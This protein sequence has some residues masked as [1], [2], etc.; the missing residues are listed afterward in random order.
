[1]RIL[2]D[3]KGKK[4][5]FKNN[6]LHTNQGFIKKEEIEDSNDGDILETHLGHKYTVMQANL[7]DYIDLMERRCSIILPK[8]IGAVNAY[9]GLGYGQVVVEAG[10]GSGATALYFA[11]TVGPEGKVYTYEVREDF[12]R[13]AGK[14]IQEYGMKNVQVKNQDIKEGIEESEIDLVFLDLP[15]PGDVVK[16][17]LNSLKVGGYLAAYNPY[18]EQV[19]TLSKV[20]KK[21]GFSEIKTI[22]CILREMEVKVK[23][24]RPKTRM[25]GHTGYL[26]IARIL[27]R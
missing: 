24:T 10:T 22:E 15:Q 17:A 16:H 20:L 26:T 8:D 6:D 12:S 4:F 7:N 9:T 5:V 27:R 18:I 14:N 1:M 25:V 21:F 3:N 11:N 19:I 2:I 13:I 23:G